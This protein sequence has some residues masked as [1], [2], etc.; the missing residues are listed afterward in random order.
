VV[1][2]ENRDNW[3]SLSDSDLRTAVVGDR[4]AAQL[5]ETFSQMSLET[6]ED[7]M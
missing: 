6:L 2:D 4:T 7:Y 1:I 3:N 5:Y